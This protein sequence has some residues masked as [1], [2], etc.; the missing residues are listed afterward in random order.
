MTNKGDDHATRR[1]G[2]AAT[3]R[4][5]GGTTRRDS[6]S[7]TA[8]ENGHVGA[9]TRDGVG[10]GRE[11]GIVLPDYLAR[12]YTVVD[13]LSTGGEATVAVVQHRDTGAI[14]V[15]KIYRQGITLPQSM[16]DKLKNA[17]GRH[18]LRVERSLYTGW[19]TPRFVEVMD[20]LPAG[21]LAVMLDN[22]PGGLPDLA[23]QILTEMTDALEYIH[24]GLNLVHRDIKPANVLIRQSNPLDLVLADLGIAS[25][26]DEIARSRR[27]T[28]GSVKG[29]PAYQS[30]ETLNSSDAGRARDWWA[31]GMT[32]CEVLTGQHPFKDSAG[33]ELRDEGRI[34]QAITMGEIDLSIITDDRWNLLS[35]GLLSHHP[36]DR[37]G[38]RQVRAW[39]AG[40]SPAVVSRQRA[41]AP[42]RSVA[43][44][45][46][47]GRAFTDPV[48]LS[49]HMVANWD[50]ATE[51]FSQ[52]SE[53][54][55]LRTWVREDL[56]DNSI[57]TN[58][59]S[60]VGSNSALAD[61]RIIAFT[62]HYRGPS[63]VHLRGVK[64]T[65]GDLA[66]RYLKAGGGWKDDPF[67]KLL[68]P[69]VVDALVESQ[70]NPTVGQSG[71]SP[72]YRALAQFS[73]YALDT[74]REVTAAVSEVD[75]AAS[76]HVYG[77]DIG[78]DVRRD[79]PGRIP[80]AQALARAALLSPVCLNDIRSEFS[81][82]DRVRPPWYA[83]L[84]RRA[85]PSAGGTID[86]PGIARLTLAT[87]IV[88][89]ANYY[90]QARASAEVAERQRRADAAA[91]AAADSRSRLAHLVAGAVTGVVMGIAINTILNMPQQRGRTLG[92]ELGVPGWV[93]LTIVLVLAGLGMALGYHDWDEGLDFVSTV[94]MCGMAGGP[95]TG[96]GVLLAVLVSELLDNDNIFEKIIVVIINGGLGGI[97]G[98]IVGAVAF[99]AAGI[100]YAI[101]RR[102]AVAV[103]GAS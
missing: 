90:D 95:I 25:E 94:T 36:D 1:D 58:L 15:V 55:A 101:A 63:D 91:N 13:D 6:P 102:I 26:L 14:K 8:R 76:E 78:V 72:E 59:L 79:L 93:P 11:Y 97:A 75:R 3:R 9:T 2:A 17:D 89:L 12:D 62:T 96:I 35:R 34:R 92:E 23:R 65:A 4:D 54:E 10:S 57:A 41:A 88:D 98:A 52:Q 80:R 64:V 47:A 24:D 60:T 50:K 100:V 27:E 67:L 21:S 16:I 77:A 45:M 61:A 48:A 43:S 81:T 68:Q 37:W 7:A 42:D 51:L 28:T 38:S 22:S 31:L 40:E 5:A 83:D 103:A 87:V 86:P 44:F 33:N 56:R 71:Q 49:A 53:C 39:L 19:A 66:M 73:R 99:G 20:Y 74:D 29:T 69:K 32:M 18:V 85:S 84:C 46:F 82:L 70:Y 30:P